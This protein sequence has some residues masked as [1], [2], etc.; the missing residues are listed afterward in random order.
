[1]CA[2]RKQGSHV[3]LLSSSRTL[4]LN[5]GP[6]HER[7]GMTSVRAMV[8]PCGASPRCTRATCS[9][10]HYQPTAPADIRPKAVHGVLQRCWASIEERWLGTS[11][12]HSGTTT[13]A[14]PSRDGVAKPG[15]SSRQPSSRRSPNVFLLAAW[16]PHGG[17]PRLLQHR[18]PGSCKCRRGRHSRVQSS[19]AGRHDRK[20]ASYVAGTDRSTACQQPA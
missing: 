1:M 6:F 8:S 2:E 18:L 14:H 20:P 19:A 16:S 7:A 3:A 17:G 11:S 5:R 9:R 13:K 15:V 10:G 12:R 4:F